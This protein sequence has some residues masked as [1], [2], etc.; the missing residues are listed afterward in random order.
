MCHIRE[1][2]IK[3]YGNGFL[4]IKDIGIDFKQ[5]SDKLKSGGKEKTKQRRGKMNLLLNNILNLTDEEIKNSKIELNMQPG[6]SDKTYL[7]RWLTH[8]DREKSTASCKECSFWGWGRN[9]GKDTRNYKPGQLAFSFLRTEEIDEWLFVS[10]GRIVD[11][12][13]DDYATVE[14]IEKYA[15]LF[16]R[17]IIKCNKDAPHSY[18]F[19]MNTYIDKCFVKEILANLYCGDEFKGYDKVNLEYSKLDDIFN[20]KILKTYA[21]ALET[22]K[23][24]YCL[25]DTNTGLLYIG[26]ATGEEGI[27]QRWGDYF[28]TKDG[29]NKKLKALHDKEGEEYFKKYFKFT[30]LEYFSM[31][32]DD[33]K[34]RER[35]RYWKECL[36]TCEHGYNA[37]K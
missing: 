6:D 3:M 15:P 17:M 19:N 12:P 25:T 18:V 31:G 28:R 8:S 14:I 35:E 22:I 4:R 5:A 29:G 26:S 21:T 1:V 10:A 34:I 37:N 33:E 11:V 16:G 24:V 7:D 23:G 27:K 13:K 9:W 20:K 2:K 32:Y 36:D 30:L